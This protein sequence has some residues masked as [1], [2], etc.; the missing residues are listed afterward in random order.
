MKLLNVELIF[1]N[2]PKLDDSEILDDSHYLYLK[3]N[4]PIVQLFLVPF[5]FER[6]NGKFGQEKKS[7]N[8]AIFEG[9]FVFF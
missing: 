9:I 2:R 8:F 6:K 1:S 5:F 3:P 7:R 4:R